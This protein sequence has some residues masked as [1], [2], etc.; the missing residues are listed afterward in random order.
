MVSP[1]LHAEGGIPGMGTTLYRL[2]LELIYL[3]RLKIWNRWKAGSPSLRPYELTFYFEN[4]LVWLLWILHFHGTL[5]CLFR[6]NWPI[7]FN[8]FIYWY[9]VVNIENS[10]RRW[11][12]ALHL[13]VFLLLGERKVVFNSYRYV[14]QIPL[15]DHTF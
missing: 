15:E 8:S 12:L 2:F 1:Y 11:V 9:H 6:C 14:H 10:A 4:F 7:S 3:V 13:L 5:N